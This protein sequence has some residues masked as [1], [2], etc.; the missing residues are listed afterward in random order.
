MIPCRLPHGKL[1][2]FVYG[3]Y[4]GTRDD[5][6]C[7]DLREDVHLFKYRRKPP[8]MRGRFSEICYSTGT[9]FPFV[10]V[11]TRYSSSASPLRSMESE[12]AAPARLRTW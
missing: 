10:I 6:V 11:F 7:N 8:A 1:R 2:H 4:H 3:N 9:A 12:P 5:T